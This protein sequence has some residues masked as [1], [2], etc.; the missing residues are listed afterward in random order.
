MPE[1]K[2]VNK[3]YPHDFNPSLVYKRKKA[4]KKAI[5]VRTMI[6]F[7]VCCL[8]CGSFLYKGS[9]FN[10]IKKKINYSSYLGIDIYRFYMNCNVCFSVFYFRTDPKSGSYIIER[11]VKLFDGNLNNQKR[12]KSMMGNRINK[13][14]YVS[15][16]I[17]KHYINNLNI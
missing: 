17:K 12:K 1:R 13:I 4:S 5:K 8:T 7:T 2:V 10:S 6:P 15:D 16:I 3:Y 14:K 11:G 9:K